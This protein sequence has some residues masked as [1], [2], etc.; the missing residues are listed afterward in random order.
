MEKITIFKSLKLQNVLKTG[1]NSRLIDNIQSTI[2]G[3]KKPSRNPTPPI[4]AE[5]TNEENIKSARKVFSD[6]GAEHNRPHRMSQSN[7]EHMEE[8]KTGGLTFGSSINVESKRSLVENNP[9][10]SF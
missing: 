10:G 9:Y 5:N 2:S 3:G 8:E 1:I 7:S 4:S 6:D